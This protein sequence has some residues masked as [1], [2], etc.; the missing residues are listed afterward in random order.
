M[1]LRIRDPELFGVTES[2]V[3]LSFVVADDS[4]PVDAQARVRVAGEPRAT[5]RGKGTRLVRIDGL[6]PGTEYEIAIEAAG[7][8]TAAPD[9]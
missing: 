4:G 5:S 3:T 8:A 1:P 2:S 7:A 9:R 6:E